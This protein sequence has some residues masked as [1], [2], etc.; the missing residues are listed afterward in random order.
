[1]IDI[2]DIPRE[3]TEAAELINHWMMVNGH[4]NW[5]LGPVA[6]RKQAVAALDRFAYLRLA[7]LAAV[8][9]DVMRERLVNYSF[10]C[11]DHGQRSLDLLGQLHEFGRDAEPVRVCIH[12]DCRSRRGCQ[13]PRDGGDART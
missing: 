1:M 13:S 10:R 12:Q 5:Q 11:V 2:M 3:V 6:D 9:A 7:C 4:D 8:D